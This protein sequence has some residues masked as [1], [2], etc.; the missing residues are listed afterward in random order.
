LNAVVD[1][2]AHGQRGSGQSLAQSFAF[3]KLG[4]DVVQAVLRAGVV[5]HD[6]VRVIQRGGG[7]AFLLEAADAARV[8]GEG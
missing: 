3:Q 1:G 5:E 8:A 6:D 7:A 4:G 2:L